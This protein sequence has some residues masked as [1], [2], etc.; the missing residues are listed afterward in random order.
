MADTELF[1]SGRS[2]FPNGAWF[3]ALSILI[4]LG[5]RKYVQPVVSVIPT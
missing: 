4:A 2:M 1:G 5:A 3:F